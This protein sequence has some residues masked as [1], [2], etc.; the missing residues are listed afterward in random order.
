MDLLENLAN[1]LI[2]TLITTFT[3]IISYVGIKIKEA[4]QTHINTEEKEKVIDATVK[5][6][7][8]IYSQLNG[9]EKLNEAVKIATNWLQEKN[10]NVTESEINILIESS[11][12]TLHSEF[13]DL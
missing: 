1:L 5:Y 10:I 6:V 7:E 12:Q 13:K 3:A 11:V 9:E 8:Q 2:P 4:Y